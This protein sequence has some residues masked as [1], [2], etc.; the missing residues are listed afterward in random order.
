MEVLRHPAN[1]EICQGILNGGAE[2][3]I[4]REMEDY[5]IRIEQ[6]RKRD[7]GLCPRCKRIACFASCWDKERNY[8]QTCPSFKSVGICPNRR[9]VFTGVIEIVN[10]ETDGIPTILMRE[11]PD[12]NWIQCDVCNLV[13]CKAC[14]QNPKSG[15]CNCCLARINKDG[16][17]KPVQIETGTTLLTQ[18]F[19][20]ELDAKSPDQN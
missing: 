14:C 9:K 16:A 13:V 17:E 12:R 4:E 8:C 18:N 7:W 3:E 2:I 15:Y 20:F 10:T 1:C 19:G 11:T 5:F 6:P